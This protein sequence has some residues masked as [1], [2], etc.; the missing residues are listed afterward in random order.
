KPVLFVVHRTGCESCA[1]QA[2]RVIDFAE[3]YDE[4]VK[5]YDL[6]TVSD[7]PSDIKQKANEVYK[8]DPNGPPGYIALTGIYTY[9]KENGKMT[10][11]WHTWEAPNDMKVSNS[12]LETWIKDAIYYHHKYSGEN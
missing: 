5:F 4:Y 9:I 8:Y 3:E 6:D 7:A 11:G 1:D 12:N 10:I 2:E